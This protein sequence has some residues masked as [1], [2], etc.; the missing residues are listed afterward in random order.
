M[1][2]PLFS[3]FLSLSFIHFFALQNR[4]ISIT[5]GV[6]LEGVFH[7]EGFCIFSPY[8]W[9]RRPMLAK[10]RKIRTS[11][12]RS[13][14]RQKTN[15]QKTK[16]KTQTRFSSLRIKWSKEIGGLQGSEGLGLNFI[17]TGLGWWFRN[18][19]EHE[20]WIKT[21]REEEAQGRNERDGEMDGKE[22]ILVIKRWGVQ[23]IIEKMDKGEQYV[24]EVAKVGV[25]EAQHER[26]VEVW[27]LEVIPRLDVTRPQSVSKSSWWKLFSK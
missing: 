26:E 16:K 11:C 12:L 22:G 5:T 14:F 7:S 21:D 27:P 17:T 15:K 19:T 20:S 6:A 18:V 2:R 10:T 9:F 13:Y 4:L 23:R 24:V 3:F 25:A 8:S 1:I